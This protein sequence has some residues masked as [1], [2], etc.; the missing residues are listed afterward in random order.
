M[1]NGLQHTFGMTDQ[2]LNWFVSYFDARLM[3]VR[4]SGTSSATTVGTMA[5]RRAHPSDLCA[6]TYTLLLCHL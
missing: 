1:I 3:F 2:A 6:S 4:R 5:S